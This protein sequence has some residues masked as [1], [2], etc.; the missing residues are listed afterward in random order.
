MIAFPQTPQHASDIRTT[1]L[2][3]YQLVRLPKT[4]LLRL[5]ILLHQL[6][7][8]HIIHHNNAIRILYQPLGRQQIVIR[9]D[10]DVRFGGEDRVGLDD[11][12]GEG[13]GDAFEEEGAEAGT[14]AACYRVG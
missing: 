3:T 10:R 12:L 2:V 1:K 7:Q 4:R 5:H 13:V 14:G 9:L 8:L 11:F 6:V